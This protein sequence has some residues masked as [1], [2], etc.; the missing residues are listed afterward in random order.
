M[1]FCLT[2]GLFSSIIEPAKIEFINGKTIEGKLVD[3]QKGQVYLAIDDHLYIVADS[4][5]KSIRFKEKTIN[6]SRLPLFLFDRLLWSEYAEHIKILDRSSLEDEKSFHD[7]NNADRRIHEPDI[8]KFGGVF[9]V[10]TS[11][12]QAAYGNSSSKRFEYYDFGAVFSF[13]SSLDF[14]MSWGGKKG[15]DIKSTS[16]S[17]DALLKPS[18][19]TSLLG[20]S[21]NLIYNQTKE[22]WRI[23]STGV[24][25][26][27]LFVNRPTDSKVNVIPAFGVFCMVGNEGNPSLFAAWAFDIN[28]RFVSKSVIL[29]EIGGGYSNREMTFSVAG[30]LGLPFAGL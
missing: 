16:Y 17:I 25:G 10:G 21:L 9:S 15:T 18:T 13:R 7:P 1:L 6:M 11:S 27:T 2:T 5:I 29:M 4:L 22:S 28:Y 24:G 20:L 26:I 30:G 19:S 14:G 12:L 23:H 8:E 3:C